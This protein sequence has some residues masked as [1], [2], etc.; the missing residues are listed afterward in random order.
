[1]IEFDITTITDDDGIYYP[2]EDRCIVYLRS[3]YLRAKDSYD[4]TDL[5]LIGKINN[6]IQHEVYHSILTNTGIE[7]KEDSEHY[8][9]D[10]LMEIDLE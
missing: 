2:I 9:I 4:I 7:M 5:Y 8:I 6:V 3:I 10:E 1:M